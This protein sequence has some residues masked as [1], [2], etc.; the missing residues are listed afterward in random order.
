MDS[1][2]TTMPTAE[3]IGHVRHLA[4]RRLSASRIAAKLGTTRP[5]VTAF[6]ARHGI[7][8]S[9]HVAPRFAAEMA[10]EQPVDGEA[11]AAPTGIGFLDLTHRT[12]R[13]PLWGN[14]EQVSGAD[15]RF[16]GERVEDGSIYC[17]THAA[18][19]R[20]RPVTKGEPQDAEP[21]GAEQ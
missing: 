21:Q 1:D 9:R 2:W 5:V 3:R 20:P 19:F 12:C 16:C 15:Y 10:A 8:L 13:A 14:R 11:T 4:G 18:E 7:D 6:A 17:P